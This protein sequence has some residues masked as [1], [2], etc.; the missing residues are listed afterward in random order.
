MVDLNDI[1][2]NRI[3]PFIELLECVEKLLRTQM[4][5]CF[6]SIVVVFNKAPKELNKRPLD[7]SILGNILKHKI[8]DDSKLAV[9]PM[10][11][12]LVQHLVD[13]N[14]QI[15]LFGLVSQPGPIGDDLDRGASTAILAARSIDAHSLREVI[16]P[17]LA[18]HSITFLNRA[19]EKLSSDSAFQ[20]LI[21][22]TEISIQEIEYYFRE[23]EQVHGKCRHFK[24]ERIYLILNLQEMLDPEIDPF[25]KLSMLVERFPD[26]E[27]KIKEAGLLEKLRLLNF[28]D[29]IL[30]GRRVPTQRAFDVSLNTLLENLGR[31][32]EMQLRASGNFSRRTLEKARRRQLEWW[33]PSSSS[34]SD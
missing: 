31:R 32:V 14:E 3:S 8:L 30:E 13:N 12:E 21:Q 24:K 16:F 7:V 1:V 17:S 20:K 11:R 26:L 6:S 33:R 15:G 19:R 4:R 22:W 5:R 2:A 25:R 10:G 18:E 29:Y 23:K 9:S 27:L 28:V 34:D